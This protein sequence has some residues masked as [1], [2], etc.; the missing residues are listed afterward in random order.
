VRLLYW[1]IK[2]STL[3]IKIVTVKVTNRLLFEELL[4][5]F[6]MKKCKRFIKNCIFSNSYWLTNEWIDNCCVFNLDEKFISL[7]RK[8]HLLISLSHDS[9]RFFWESRSSFVTKIFF[10]WSSYLRTSLSFRSDLIKIAYSSS[11]SLISR[12][13]RKSINMKEIISIK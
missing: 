2:Y 5:V 9:S 6:G 13:S 11:C 3:Y 12:R 1:W 8:S 10:F 4:K 7:Y